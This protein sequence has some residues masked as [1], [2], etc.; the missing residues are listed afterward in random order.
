MKRQKKTDK[1]IFDGKS[2]QSLRAMTEKILLL[3]WEENGWET[4]IQ[5][6]EDELM[7]SCCNMVIEE[8]R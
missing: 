6:E 3:I 8:E 1:Q 5:E 4:G 7:C 2:L